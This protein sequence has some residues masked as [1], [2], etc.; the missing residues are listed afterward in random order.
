MHIVNSGICL[1][2]CTEFFQKISMIF[3]SVFCYCFHVGELRAG[4]GRGSTGYESCSF[5]S[6]CMLQFPTDLIFTI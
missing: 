3:M 5:L 1:L 6:D 2:T 4:G